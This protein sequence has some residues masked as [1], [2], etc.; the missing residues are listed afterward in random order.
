MKIFRQETIRKHFS[1]SSRS[2]VTK[3]KK[4]DTKQIAYTV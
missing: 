4:P 1:C 2:K 3:Y